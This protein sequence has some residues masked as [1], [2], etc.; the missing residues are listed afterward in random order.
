MVLKDAD[1]IVAVGEELR[2]A[3]LGDA[4]L[5]R[6]PQASYKVRHFEYHFSPSFPFA[7]SGSAYAQYQIHSLSALC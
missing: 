3:S 2:I 4:R 5:G 1:L 7:S 6:S